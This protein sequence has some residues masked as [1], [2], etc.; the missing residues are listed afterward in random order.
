MLDIPNEDCF[1][2]KIN[3]HWDWNDFGTN[4]GIWLKE[5]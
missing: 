4:R 5:K 3:N 1:F 2:M